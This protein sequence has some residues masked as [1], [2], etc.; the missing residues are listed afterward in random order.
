MTKLEKLIARKERLE[1]YLLNIGNIKVAIKELE[2]QIE[3]EKNKP[4]YTNEQR[5][6]IA[7]KRYKTIFE[8]YESGQSCK[9]IAEIEGVTVGRIHYIIRYYQSLLRRDE[10]KSVREKNR[11]LEKA[12]A[13]RSLNIML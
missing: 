10:Y 13:R 8:L 9:Q 3:I 12:D 4:H 5:Q 2:E 1:K 6:A 11:E 7:R